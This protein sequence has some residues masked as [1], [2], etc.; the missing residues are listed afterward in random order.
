MAPRLHTIPCMLLTT[1]LHPLRGACPATA[2]AA[3]T[4]ATAALAVEETAALAAAGVGAFD[5]L[6]QPPQQQNDECEM[7]CEG[8]T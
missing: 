7:E 4:A 6:R 2:T 8:P 3:V 5:P 1:P